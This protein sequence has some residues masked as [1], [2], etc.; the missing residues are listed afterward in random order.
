MNLV[1]ASP[2]IGWMGAERPGFWSR[3]RGELVLA[4]A[5]VHHLYFR[6]NLP[7][8]Q[9]AQGLDA[10]CINSLV[11]EFV[12][13]GDPKTAMLAAGRTHLLAGYN[14][15][16]FCAAMSVYFT[17]EETV[18]LAAAGRILYRMKKKQGE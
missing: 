2:A 3:F 15:E 4:L 5:L 16:A 17:I 7:F 12:Q 6:Y 14:N 1:Q 8:A 18:P 11:I 13:P 9:L 10:L